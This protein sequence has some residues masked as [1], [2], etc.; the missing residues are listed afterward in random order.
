[1]ITIRVSVEPEIGELI[2][3]TIGTGIPY[4][5]QDCAHVLI[6]CITPD[7]LRQIANIIEELPGP[8]GKWPRNPRPPC[9]PPA[10]LESL[11]AGDR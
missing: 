7:E 4:K 8:R 10:L 9:L 2:A 6:P 1:M 5:K 11:R 3:A